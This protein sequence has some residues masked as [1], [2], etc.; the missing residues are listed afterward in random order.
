MVPIKAIHNIHHAAAVYSR[1]S[2]NVIM[3]TV[4][5]KRVRIAIWQA[6]RHGWLLYAGIVS[7]PTTHI[8]IVQLSLAVS[9][10]LTGLSTMSWCMEMANPIWTLCPLHTPG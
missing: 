10:L 7:G 3:E 4:I 1:F 8:L 2:S 5:I 6:S 9:I